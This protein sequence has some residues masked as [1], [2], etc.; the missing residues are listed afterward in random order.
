MGVSKEQTARNRQ[1]IVKA[2][3]K[4]FRRRGERR[5][6]TGL[7]EAFSAFEAMLPPKAPSSTRGPSSKVGYSPCG[8]YSTVRSSRAGI[9]H[10]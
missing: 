3:A 7:T 8:S 10:G 2:A 5:F 4:L 6:A 1:A 9:L